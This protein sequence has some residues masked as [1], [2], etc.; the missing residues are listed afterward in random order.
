MRPQTLVM[1]LLALGS[2]LGAMVLVQKYVNKEPVKTEGVAVLVALQD[3]PAG[4]QLNDQNVGEIMYAGKITPDTKLAA[5]KEKVFGRTASVK[6]FKDDLIRDAKLG[7]AGDSNLSVMLRRREKTGEMERAV[8]VKVATTGGVA[9]FVRPDSLVDVAIYLP[10]MNNR[11]AMFRTFLKNM[12][13]IAVNSQMQRP[14]E[15]QPQGQQVDMVTFAA[16]KEEAEK[17]S[18]AESSGTIKLMLRTNEDKDTETTGGITLD[19][20]LRGAHSGQ[21]TEVAKD[22]ADKVDP[23][24]VRNDRNAGVLDSITKIFAAKAA[25][26]SKGKADPLTPA[27]EP[28]T[29]AKDPEPA[30]E[31]VKVA[32]EAPQKKKYKWVYRDQLGNPVMEVILDDDSKWVRSLK[33]TGQLEPL[34]AA[35]AKKEAKAPAIVVPKPVA[36]KTAKR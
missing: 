10:P 6:F 30:K 35:E 17:L 12:R 36:P 28:K 18:L 26:T 7:T 29:D 8:A 32:S 5:D 13:I 23:N 16:S 34:D 24:L 11:P 21:A 9:G 33:D 1:L 20:L 31:D 22:D 19:A 3:I 2:G 27:E 25:E 15:V 4:S 14:N